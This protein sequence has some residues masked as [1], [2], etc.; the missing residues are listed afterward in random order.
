MD[1]LVPGVR[2][3]PQPER[4][5]TVG[6]IAEALHHIA[7]AMSDTQ[8]MTV[9]ESIVGWVGE[10]AGA[11]AHEARHIQAAVR[12]T[13]EAIAG[14][15]TALNEYQAVCDSLTQQITAHQQK[16]DANIAWYKKAVS[17][18]KL[19]DSGQNFTELITDATGL[20]KSKPIIDAAGLMKMEKAYLRVQLDECQADEARAYNRTVE[21]VDAAAASTAAKLRAAIDAVVPSGGGPG[22]GRGVPSRA[23]VGLALFGGTKGI[24]AAQSRWAA[25]QADA[26][27]AAA[28]IDRTDGKTGVP[29]QAAVRQFNATY[30]AR[31]ASDPYFATMLMRHIGAEKLYSITAAVRGSG[32]SDS[33]KALLKVF[34]ANMGAGLILA[35]GGSSTTDTG[36]TTGFKALDKALTV[37]GTKTVRQW[38]S[39]FQAALNKY[40]QKEFLPDGKMIA[41]E[42]PASKQ[43]GRSV[44]TVTPSRGYEL[45][46][47]YLAYGAKAHP[48]L[49]VGDH[50]L[51]GVDGKNSV[52]HAMVDYDMK[53]PTNFNMKHNIN[54]VHQQ[55]GALQGNMKK[56]SIFEDG[57]SWD[58]IQH[59]YEA[60]DNAPDK[61][62]SQEFMNSKSNFY[63]DHDGKSSTPN[64][65]MNMARYLVGNR[66]CMTEDNY[67][68]FS[69]STDDKG[70][71]LGRLINEISGDTSNPA[72]VNIARESIKGYNDGLNRNYD[73]VGPVEITGKIGGQNAFGHENSGFR[74]H[75][76]NIL[77]EY[78]SDIVE[79]K[80][81]YTGIDKGPAASW[82]VRDKRY[83]LVFDEELFK[84]MSDEVETD[85][86]SNKNE[87]KSIK[88]PS[89][90]LKD[91]A[92]DKKLIKEFTK[93]TMNNLI[94]DY[95]QAYTAYGDDNHKNNLKEYVVEN[96]SNHLRALKKAELQAGIDESDSTVGKIMRFFKEINK[97][98]VSKVPVIGRDLQGVG[99]KLIE[100]VDD[101]RVNKIV[102][103]HALDGA[104]VKIEVSDA[105]RIVHDGQIEIE[106]K[107][108]LESPVVK[109]YGNPK[110]GQSLQDIPDVKEY[111]NMLP[112]KEQFFDENGKEI[113]H[114]SLKKAQE[115][116]RNR[117][118]Y[119]KWNGQGG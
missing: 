38:R 53:H 55:S 11:F 9:G 28:L 29:S 111:S 21:A 67:H 69:L 6:S 31:L 39:D 106:H 63:W 93:N 98:G 110:G 115:Q 57:V 30:G 43:S 116:A 117:F 3:L 66:K 44:G 36:T 7:G 32:V 40:G 5:T 19:P 27:A 83:H 72:S 73:R 15:V 74:S 70:N 47:Q 99:D 2:A 58:Y 105:T 56:S 97:F 45:L 79:E 23:A 103:D 101:N 118:H 84:M 68:N 37:D 65:P 48:E 1:S 22:G 13:Q 112:K 51:N 62:P 46:G 119:N 75:I 77:Q 96:Y 41:D 108:K 61:T 25:A 10:S 8:V 20:M 85:N 102:A 50:F 18:V 80:K 42:K 113:P 4:V 17:E 35:T 60:M 95:Y 91:I 86:N 87:P 64:E 78:M 14:M 92:H 82:D 100:L 54:D 107:E 24:L 89:L 88:E 16:W 104:D 34:T 12:K 49:S 90:F 59:L 76:G 71:A 26:P 114:D 52:A 109:K 81:Q 33:H 94:T